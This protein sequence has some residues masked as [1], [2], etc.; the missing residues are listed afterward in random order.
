MNFE[1]LANELI[2]DIF[3]YLNSI[4]LLRTFHGLN[5]RFNK[6]LYLHFQRFPLDFRSV[7]KHEFDI[8]CQ[9]ILPLITDQITS[10]HLSNDDDTPD[11][12]NLF[13]SYGFH[14]Q[15]FINLQSLSL[16]H[17][18]STNLI[19]QIILNCPHL[20]YLNISKCD[21]DE[22]TEEA[23]SCINNIWNL[24]NLKY[25]YLN[26]FFTS[27]LTIIS[28]SLEDL[29]IKN[30]FISFNCLISLFQCTPNLQNLSIRIRDISD[31]KP[32]SFLIPLL[33]KLT[34]NFQGELN[35]LTNL[36][37]NLPNLSK[38]IIDI[39]NIYIDGYQW[40]EIITNYLHKLKVF[41]LLMYYQFDDEKIFNEK[42]NELFESFQTK[43]WIDEH[44]WFIQ[45]DQ[46]TEYQSFHLYTLPYG[47]QTFINYSS[48]ISK[49]TCPIDKNYNSSNYVN[50][51]FLKNSLSRPVLQFPNIHHLELT[52]PFNDILWS[53]IPKF[54][55]LISLEIISITH[56]DETDQS[57]IR[58]RQLFDQAIHL[59]S[60]TI[61]Y[62]IIS[63]LSSIP[64]TNKSIHRLDL[65]A[66]DGHFY[67]FE[68]LV[69][70]QSLL[71]DQCEV[72]LINLENRYI[73]LDLI[74]KMSKLRAL[75][76]QCQDDQWGDSNESFLIEDEL[77]QWLKNRLPSNCLI[78]RD[79]REMSAIRLWIR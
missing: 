44:Q 39:E 75:T 29:S 73:V 25:C 15:Q 24:T 63:Q 78:V 48:D 12:P 34:I 74:E 8:I 54:D 53:I 11:Q 32:L 68:C 46:H 26:D 71:G 60:L 64:I 61:D 30:Y 7:S 79:E 28:S 17:I 1:L 19:N 77:V 20:I 4:Q 72:L 3:E 10:I 59:Y 18:R 14:F 56:S 43:F 33:T 49:S 2:L 70:I 57:I 21:F 69:L 65:M 58:L 45:Y 51:L 41:R 42:I 5:I 13:F 52:F 27:L 9:R 76:F 47:F 36:L 35:T 22:D 16:Y 38:L 62:L 66:N 23:K 37:E 55:H 67:D 50:T 31:N 40:E 6:L